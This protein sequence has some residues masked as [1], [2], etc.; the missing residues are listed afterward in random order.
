MNE[1]PPHCDFILI[2]AKVNY[3]AFPP[4][5]SAAKRKK[6]CKS[7]YTSDSPIDTMGQPLC[8]AIASE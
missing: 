6:L 8:V 2:F 7:T 4:Y 3:T 5:R 1:I